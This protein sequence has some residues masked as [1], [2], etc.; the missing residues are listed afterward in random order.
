MSSSCWKGKKH[1]NIRSLLIAKEGGKVLR[2][3]FP[4]CFFIA[5]PERMGQLLFLQGGNFP[6]AIDVF[7]KQT[8]EDFK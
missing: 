2:F 7:K 4:V 5:V 1:I 6:S 3:F 8:Q